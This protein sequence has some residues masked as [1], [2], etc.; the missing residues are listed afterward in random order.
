MTGEQLAAAVRWGS[1]SRVLRAGFTHTGDA[2]ILFGK[3]AKDIRKSI[4]SAHGKDT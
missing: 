2:K 1:G 4:D 3:W